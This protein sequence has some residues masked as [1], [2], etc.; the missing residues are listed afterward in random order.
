MMLTCVSGASGYSPL[1][2]IS[3]RY[4]DYYCIIATLAKYVFPDGGGGPSSCRA[5]GWYGHIIVAAWGCMAPWPSRRSAGHVAVSSLGWRGV[6][7]V[8]VEEWARCRRVVVGA[9]GQC[10][11]AAGRALWP[12]RSSPRPRGGGPS[13]QGAGA[14]WPRRQLRRAVW[15][16]GHRVEVRGVWPYRHQGRG[17]VWAASL[18]RSGR[19]VIVS[20]S[21]HDDSVATP[22]GGAVAT[23]F[24]VEAQ[25]RWA[26]VVQGAGAVWPRRRH[27]AGLYGPMVID[28][29]LP[30]FASSR[31]HVA[32]HFRVS[33]RGEILRKK[34]GKG[35]YLRCMAPWPSS[36]LPAFASRFRASGRGEIMRKKEGKGRTCARLGASSAR[37]H[38]SGRGLGIV[39]L[40]LF[41]YHITHYFNRKGY[42]I[43]LTGP[44]TSRDR[45]RDFQG[46]T[47]K[48]SC[49]FGMCYSHDSSGLQES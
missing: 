23:S 31:I 14:V 39:Y 38:S 10:G 47:S 45:S 25:G 41:S 42:F 44:G 6:G 21:G 17:A 43:F 29:R 22:Q 19:G 27:C 3:S 7:R 24:V 36:R 26:V 11:H 1:L 5:W 4:Y 35:A 34:E 46:G 48:A 18:L 16:C 12:R 20:S 8:V 49:L 9:W 33:G 40:M 15:P 13:S 28:M 32:S 37:L 2:V 30:T